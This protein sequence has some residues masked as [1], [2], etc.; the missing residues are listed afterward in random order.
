MLRAEILHNSQRAEYSDR[1]V[2]FDVII[3][4]MKNSGVT[5]KRGRNVHLTS[6]TD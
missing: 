5:A 3:N 6:T 2:N 1:R 4:T